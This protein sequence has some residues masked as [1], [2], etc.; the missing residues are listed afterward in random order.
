M[1]ALADCKGQ[2]EPR[3]KQERVRLTLPAG[4]QHG[5]VWIQGKLLGVGAF[6]SVYLGLT[7]T[8]KLLAAKRVELRGGA[9]LYVESFEREEALLKVS[10]FAPV[11]LHSCSICTLPWLAA[12]A[13]PARRSVC[14][15][16]ASITTRSSH[17]DGVCRR[18]LC[19]LSDK[20]VWRPQRVMC[21]R[22]CAP[23]RLGPALSAC[24]LGCSS[25]P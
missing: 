12:P 20:R 16:L 18:W 15:F 11:A 2:L 4:T 13:T 21:P 6:G 5:S 17:L 7:D 24:Q 10:P 3:A 9:T 19:R 23:N 14:R 1:L 25:R 22:V 8:G